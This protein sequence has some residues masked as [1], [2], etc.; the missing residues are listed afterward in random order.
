MSKT[1]IVIPCYNEEKRI[2]F[3]A[4]SSLLEDENIFLLFVDDGSTDN[5]FEKL[6]KIKS[7]CSYNA[8]VLKLIKNKGKGEAVR[9]GMRK[10]ISY[11]CEI[12]G[13]LDA[14]LS[15]PPEEMKRLI[16]ILRHSDVS[17][18]LGSRVRLLGHTI[19][20]NPIRH[21]LGRIFATIAS[22]ILRLD[23][24]DTQCG[25]KL[26]FVTP[27]LCWS[28]DS[29]FFSR[30]AFDIELIYRLIHPAPGISPLNRKNFLEVP[31]YSWVHKS[32]SNLGFPA[33]IRAG[34]DLL[35]IYRNLPKSTK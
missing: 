1:V 11:G 28:L 33:M 3:K 30:W 12:V 24:Y 7:S 29:P 32:D 8:D 10:A 9:L 6:L 25:A 31:L 22:M 16:E 4:F 18:V 21:Y 15:T 23:V 35:S 2:D 5:T 19:I 17:V 14:D 20:R 13:F 27:T 26:F 34:L